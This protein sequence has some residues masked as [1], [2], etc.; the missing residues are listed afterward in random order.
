MN[1]F[2]THPTDADNTSACAQ[3]RCFPQGT[4]Q[5]VQGPAQTSPNVPAPQRSAAWA[6]GTFANLEGRPSARE[7]P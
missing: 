3:P 7:H 2:K 6:V 5:A 4:R 1:A